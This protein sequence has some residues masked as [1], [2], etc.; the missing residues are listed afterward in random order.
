MTTRDIWTLAD[1][2]VEAGYFPVLE[3]KRFV[4]SVHVLG[5]GWGTVH[6]KD[7]IFRLHSP[8]QV[9]LMSGKTLCFLGESSS[10][11]KDLSSGVRPPYTG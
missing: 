4:L 1:L 5:T 8:C 3:G 2:C 9:W 7:V 10:L 6:R 11:P